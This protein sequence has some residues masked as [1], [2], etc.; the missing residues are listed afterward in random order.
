MGRYSEWPLGG[1][2]QALMKMSSTSQTISRKVN[3]PSS[4]PTAWRPQGSC[5]PLFPSPSPQHRLER[6]RP[7]TPERQPEVPLQCVQSLEGQAG[8][9]P[10]ASSQG[11][12]E[13]TGRLWLP[14]VSSPLCLCLS[15]ADSEMRRVREQVLFR[16]SLPPPEQ[17]GSCK[18]YWSSD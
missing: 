8:G 12:G 4:G 6:C 14:T 5:S 10:S 16:V 15:E 2:V 13:L 1:L 17:W 9:A 7:R 11:L 18:F 3:G